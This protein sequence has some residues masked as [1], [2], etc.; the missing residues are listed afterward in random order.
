M[1]VQL[2]CW[3][4]QLKPV[5]DGAEGDRVDHLVNLFRACLLPNLVETWVSWLTM[6][7]KAWLPT[8]AAFPE[9]FLTL[10]HS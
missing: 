4:C 6:Q 10:R 3:K 5:S 2:P 1:V 8:R 9:T 7:D